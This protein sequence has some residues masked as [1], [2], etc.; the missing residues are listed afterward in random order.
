MS[1]KIH[2]ILNFCWHFCWHFCP[3]GG[4]IGTATTGPAGEVPGPIPEPTRASGG[5]PQ[6]SP[7]SQKRPKQKCQQKLPKFRIFVDISSFWKIYIFISKTGP[8]KCC[9]YLWSCSGTL[10][11]V[12]LTE[13]V[14]EFFIF[15]HKQKFSFS[16]FSEFLLT[17]FVD[18]GLKKIQIFFVVDIFE[19]SCPV[20]FRNTQGHPVTPS[21]P[22][23]RS[24]WR[25]PV[26][27]GDFEGFWRIL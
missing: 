18:T 19:R 23:E 14:W 13:Y 24:A 26:V 11:G 1:T 3:G 8:K 9:S 20:A 12:S 5:P 16:N 2:Q 4:R 17:F 21:E 25:P 27:F 15:G 22:G 10:S 6:S 7:R